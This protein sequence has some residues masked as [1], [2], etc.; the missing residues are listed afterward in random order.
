MLKKSKE[1]TD[2]EVSFLKMV[3]SQNFVSRLKLHCQTPSFSLLERQLN[4]ICI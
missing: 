3:T 1:S 4:N 2:R